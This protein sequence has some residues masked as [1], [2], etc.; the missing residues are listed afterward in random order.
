MLED[1]IRKLEGLRIRVIYDSRQ[2]LVGLL[3]GEM[4]PI[5][6]RMDKRINFVVH[7]EHALRKVE[8]VS[9]QYNREIFRDVRV[10]K[11]GNKPEV[12]FGRLER[13]IRM[14]D[15]NM[16]K[17]LNAVF[18][19]FREGKDVVFLFGFYTIMFFHRNSLPR[20]LEI[21]ESV[22]SMITLIMPQPVDVFGR[23]VNAIVGKIFD[24]DFVIRR[25]EEYLEESYTV[26]IEQ[27]LIPGLK[28]FGKMEISEGKPKWFKS[29]G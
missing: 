20:F 14:K 5:F 27:S 21:F 19:S 29:L 18:K 3:F 28:F 1:V 15:K 22:P 23:S 25:S 17:K 12:P 26:H 2:A 7:S 11:I 13:F 8:I 10:F 24:L 6:V 4:L 16:F 9:R